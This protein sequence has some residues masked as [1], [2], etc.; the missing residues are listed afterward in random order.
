MFEGDIP[1]GKIMIF[2]P[3]GFGGPDLEAQCGSTLRW[4]QEGGDKRRSNP[5]GS[6]LPRN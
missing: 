1:E 5:E 6:G 4:D 3:A 2:C